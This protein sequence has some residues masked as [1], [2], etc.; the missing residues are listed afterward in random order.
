ML[1]DVCSLGERVFYRPGYGLFWCMV[2]VSLRRICVLC[3]F[4]ENYVNVSYIQLADEST[5]FNPILV[6]FL[7]V[8]SVSY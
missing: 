2:C 5:Q 6:N 3:C 7:P 4:V 8:G 1:Y